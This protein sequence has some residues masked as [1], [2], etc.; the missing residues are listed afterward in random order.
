MTGMSII[1]QDSMWQHEAFHAM[2]RQMR[3]SR[4]VGHVRHVSKEMH[5]R[6]AV[7]RWVRIT[8]KCQMARDNSKNKASRS[9]TSPSDFPENHTTQ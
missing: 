4:M 9:G 1:A 8:G 6:T 5:L 2:Q 7:R 3:G